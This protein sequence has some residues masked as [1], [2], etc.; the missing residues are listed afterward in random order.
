MFS[1]HALPVAHVAQTEPPQSV[2]VSLASFIPSE[3]VGWGTMQTPR[4]PQTPEQQLAFV[5]QPYPVG[6]HVVPIAVHSP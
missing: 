3:H 2:S 1:K 6:L 4:A 5:L